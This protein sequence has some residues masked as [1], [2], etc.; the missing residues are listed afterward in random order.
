MITVDVRDEIAKKIRVWVNGI[1][2]TECAFWAQLPDQPGVEADGIVDTY[3]ID[4]RNGHITT[5]GHGGPLVIQKT[6]L[7]RWEYISEPSN[8]REGS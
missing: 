8:N 5:D 3:L 7:V 2:V 4:F 1:D 6:G